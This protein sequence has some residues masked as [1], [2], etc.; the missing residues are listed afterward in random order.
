MRPNF[1]NECDTDRIKKSNHYTRDITAKRVTS[2]GAQP[3]GLAS[4]QRSS[5]ETSLQW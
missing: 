4:G 2:D 1:L 5:E 3:S